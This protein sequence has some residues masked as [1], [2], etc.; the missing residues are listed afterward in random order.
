DAGD[1]SS[2]EAILSGWV[3]EARRDFEVR[4]KQAAFRATSQLKGVQNEVFAET[5]I[6]WPSGDGQHI[7]V[8]LVKSVTDL[9]RVRPGAVVHFTSRRGVE[10]GSERHPL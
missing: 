8:V 6:F 9:M 7:D 10:G 1:R 4:R 2:L 3:P 5:A